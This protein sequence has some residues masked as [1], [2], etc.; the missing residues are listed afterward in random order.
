MKFDKGFVVGLL[1]KAQ[2]LAAAGMTYIVFDLF[3]DPAELG[4]PISNP[5]R[6]WW[7]AAAA[8][9]T[10]I[11]AI[12]IF[13]KKRMVRFAGLAVGGGV[14]FAL[15]ITYIVILPHITLGVWLALALGVSQLAAAGVV[16][17]LPEKLNDLIDLN[18]GIFVLESNISALSK[19]LSDLEKEVLSLKQKIL[20]QDG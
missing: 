8:L 12:S 1:L 13:F 6:G 5:A 2:T 20:D 14:I 16:Y 9:A 15:G 11:S 17:W 10:I 19:G 18:E 7:A 4:D 3:N